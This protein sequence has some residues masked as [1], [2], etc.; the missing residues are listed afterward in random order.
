MK[1]TRR[2]ILLSLYQRLHQHGYHRRPTI[3][4][5]PRATCRTRQGQDQEP[6]ARERG[7]EEGR[8]RGESGYRRLTCTLITSPPPRRADTTFFVLQEIFN[9]PYAVTAFRSYAEPI[10]SS[11]PVPASSLAEHASESESVAALSGMAKTHGVWLIGGSIPEIEKATDKIFNTCTVYNPQGTLS[12][13][14]LF[15]QTPD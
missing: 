8:P 1:T 5:R 15:P 9:S 13:S 7:R 6:S 14:H 4:A 2:A 12:S 10:P 3:Q 11:F